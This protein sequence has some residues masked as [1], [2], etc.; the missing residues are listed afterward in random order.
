MTTETRDAVYSELVSALGADHVREATG[1]DAIDDVRPRWTVSVDDTEQASS[2]MR[3]AA[4][5]ELRVV[6]RGSGSK[7]DWGQSPGAAD[8]VID[9]SRANRIVE[10]AAGDLVLHAQAGATLG[11]IQRVVSRTG[12]QLSLEH[13]L[14]AAT[15]GGV[16]AT[17]SAGPSRHLFGSVRETA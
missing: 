8:L 14:G 17:A 1:D 10:H 5:H 4:E 15:L 6:P 16:I 7:L 13:P 9:V 2:A 12:Q 3:I 11:E